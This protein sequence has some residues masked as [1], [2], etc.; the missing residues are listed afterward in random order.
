MGKR[1]GKKKGKPARPVALAAAKTPA[2]APPPLPTQPPGEPLWKRTWVKI[3]GALAFVT[4][5]I[6]LYQFFSSSV[7][8]TLGEPLNEDAL[9]TPFTITNTSAFFTLTDI[10]PG[11]YIVNEKFK[12]GFVLA[13]AEMTHYGGLIPELAP[14]KYDTLYCDE[15]LLRP[16]SGGTA[17]ADVIIKV[18]YST[19][20]RRRM[21]LFRFITR[22]KSDGKL[23][24]VHYGVKDVNPDFEKNP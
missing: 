15:H 14:G 8:V 19:Y 23:V 2:L 12:S 9:S 6:T 4:V 11:C 17:N 18:H 21:D 24:W 1:R 20:L 7:S 3:A 5:L 16:P 10:E 22:T 13:N